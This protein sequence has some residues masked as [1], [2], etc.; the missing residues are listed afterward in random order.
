MSELN[1]W[2]LLI[3]MLIAQLPAIVALCWKTY[4]WIETLSH[5]VDAHG[6]TMRRSFAENDAAHDRIADRV[7]R[8]CNGD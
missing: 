3:A 8:L 2:Q 7:E 6:E 1:V 5:K 4:R